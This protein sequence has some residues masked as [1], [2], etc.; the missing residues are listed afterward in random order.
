M[1]GT[2]AYSSKAEYYARYRW[3]YAPEAM[4]LL[5][6]RAGISPE[7]EV[8]DIGS[9]TGILSKHFAGR[10]A[11]I[12]SVEP[13][14]EMRGMAEQMLGKFPAF[15]SINGSAEATTLRDRSV[16]VIA[17]AQ[18]IHWFDPEPTRREFLRIARPECWLALLRNYGTDEEIGKGLWS[19]YTEGNGAIP[20][21]KVERPP[22]KPVDFYYGEYPFEAL[23][24]P[25][26]ETQSWE[27]FLGA[28]LSA[29]FTPSGDHPRYPRFES[30]VREVFEAFSVG[31][32]V[33]THGNTEL[34][35][36][37]I[38]GV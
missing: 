32:L 9:G 37:K 17:V 29:S 11:R 24:F 7:S 16:D 26:T 33:E 6:E 5:V 18:A 15:E 30:A 27:V 28:V 35:V 25:F 22:S 10:A 23:T 20:P 36:G 34:Q 2:T 14:A 8:A 3:D 21:E 4:D 19:T 12:F 38:A 13:N 1:D 31:G